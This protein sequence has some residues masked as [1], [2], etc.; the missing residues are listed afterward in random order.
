MR[1]F[2]TTMINVVISNTAVPCILDRLNPFL[3]GEVR[4]VAFAVTSW[5][6]EQRGSARVGERK[7]RRHGRYFLGSDPLV[8]LSKT[9]QTPAVTMVLA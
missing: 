2:Q 7:M 8:C 5:L 3:G 4:M 9:V 6:R 1:A